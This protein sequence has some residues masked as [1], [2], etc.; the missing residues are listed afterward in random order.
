MLSI[1]A[2]IIQCQKC[3]DMDIVRDDMGIY[4]MEN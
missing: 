3:Y 2:I 1:V 4:S